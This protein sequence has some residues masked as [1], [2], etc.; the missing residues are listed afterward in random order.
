MADSTTFST[1]SN[2]KRAAEKAIDA[3]TAPSIDYGLHAHEDGRIE[4]IWKTGATPAEADEQDAEVARQAIAEIEAGNERIITGD[5]LQERFDSWESATEESDG[6]PTQDE[7]GDEDPD[8]W[9]PG[10]RVQVALS[11][12]RVRL[13]TD[14]YQ[15]DS[16]YWRV[17]LDGAPSVSGL[18][19]VDQLSATDA[20][21]PEPTPK[22][23]RRGPAQPS[24]RQP[25][26]SAE[27]D[28]AAAAGVMPAKPIVTSKANPHYQK[29]FDQ[30]EKWAMADG[31]NAIRGYEVKG[32]NSY[33]K[34]VR[35]YRDRLLTAHAAA[36]QKVA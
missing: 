25:S 33:A 7:F 19:R 4:I 17:F 2:A 23:K 15:V 28:A 8:P 9:P 6:E 21:A 34:M 12:K 22:K 11:K 27:L 35:Q 5:E 20:P 16:Q 32:I 26:R 36:M 1:R 10:A 3:G 31:W 29:R 30:L 18:Y 13:G 24:N 14:D